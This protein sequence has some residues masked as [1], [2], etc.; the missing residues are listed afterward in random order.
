MD[1]RCGL[2]RPLP[3]SL[4]G[5]SSV[6]RHRH[7]CL[8]ALAW[9][10]PPQGAPWE[11]TAPP[12]SPHS[13]VPSSRRPPVLPVQPSGIL[14]LLLLF[15]YTLPFPTYHKIYFSFC[16]LFTHL[17]S[18]A[19]LHA[20]EDSNGLATSSSQYTRPGTQQMPSCICRINEHLFCSLTTRL[21]GNT[22]LEIYIYICFYIY[23]K[24]W[25]NI[26]LYIY[27]YFLISPQILY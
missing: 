22:I 1:G 2:T 17:P 10:A 27:I 25:G 11:E 15:S 8:R 4:S 13:N 3:C 18:P 20:P 26:Y 6:I 16:S 21:G 12:S 5:S 7:A 9:P 23:I 19:R 14:S 24:F